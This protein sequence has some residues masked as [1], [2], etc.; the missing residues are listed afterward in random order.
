MTQTEKMVI[1]R[2]EQLLVVNKPAGLP[3]LVD[4][5]DPDAPHLVGLLKETY[6]PLWIVHRLDRETSGVLLFA[7]T[8]VAHR[9]LNR[10]FETRR[11]QK[12]YH[13]LVTGS[14]MW[15]EKEVSLALRADGDRRHRSIADPVKGKTALTM[16][17]VLER[18]GEL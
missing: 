18:F 14:P 10:Q 11:V 7:L 17:K 4:G 15:E 1:W 6:S 9:A 8:A 12:T 5:W 13:A 2:D 16:L 3:T